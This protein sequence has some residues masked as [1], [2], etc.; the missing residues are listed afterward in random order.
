MN[1]TLKTAVT[2]FLCL[3]FTAC[4]GQNSADSAAVSSLGNDFP[5]TII[6]PELPESLEFA[7]VTY[8]LTRSDLRERLDREI[9]NLT[10][11]H[12]STLLIIKRANRYFPE[13]EPILKENNI[14]D[15]LKYLALIESNLVPD[16]RSPV[17]AL[18]LWQFMETTAKEYGLTVNSNIDE[19]LNIEKATIAACNYLKNAYKIYGEWTSVMASYNAGMVRISKELEKQKVKSALDLWL[20]NETS[21][22]IFRIFAAKIIFSNPQKYGFVLTKEQLYP[23][24]EYKKIKINTSIDDLV[25]FANEQNINYLQ[26][27]TANLWLRDSTLQNKNGVEY[28]ILIPKEKSLNYKPQKT[29]MMPK[30]GW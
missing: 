8:D 5:L 10:Y 1:K 12:A 27:K 4:Y 13:I 11:T 9:I 6:S 29:V 15:D 24:M 23:P 26:L 17:G 16:V 30:N 22:Y 3:N 2:L 7:G 18:G 19:R 21:R 14:P 25:V 28:T 20:D